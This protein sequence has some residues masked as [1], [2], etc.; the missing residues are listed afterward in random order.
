MNPLI[1]L[2][3]DEIIQKIAEALRT[4]LVNPHQVILEE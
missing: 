3:D 1:Y 4:S 2:G